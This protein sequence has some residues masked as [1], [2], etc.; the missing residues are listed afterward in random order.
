MEVQTVLIR[1]KAQIRHS[2]FIE[3]LNADNKLSSERENKNQV[4]NLS[5]LIFII[6]SVISL[7][8][9][10]I[11]NSD[12]KIELESPTLLF[13]AGLFISLVYIFS[14]LAISMVFNERY[15]YKKEF[16]KY[17]NLKISKSIEFSKQGLIYLC[18]VV[19]LF[20]S[21]K[22]MTSAMFVAIQNTI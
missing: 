3:K 4:R 14:C 21:S 19:W 1:S 6:F 2:K 16:L 22:I 5:Y 15:K 13:F 17:E 12:L 8:L 7:Y 10:S 9:I 20:L 11:I 18:F